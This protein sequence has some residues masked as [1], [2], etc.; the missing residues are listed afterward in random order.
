MNA[1]A[2]RP[3]P[4]APDAADFLIASRQCELAHLQHFLEL[5]RLIQT[6]GDLVHGLQQ[7]RGASNVYLGSAGGRFATERQGLLRETDGYRQAFDGALLEA[8]PSLI[9]HPVSSPLLNHVAC[10]LHGLSGLP[11]LRSRVAACEI[12]AP[13]ATDAYARL[14]HNLIA[15]VFEAADMAVDPSIAGLLVAMVHL[16]NGKELCGQER[17]AG[18]AGFSSGRFSD[19]LSERMVHLAEAQERCFEVF[20]Q[21]ASDDAVALWRDLRGHEREAQIEHLRRLGCSVGPY[22]PLDQALAD[23]WFALMSERM[24]ALKSVEN[25]LEARFHARCAERYA[26]ARHALAHQET[27]VASLT[28]GGTPAPPRLA[29]CDPHAEP[30]QVDA[31]ASEELAGPF[32]RSLL[33]LVQDQARRLQQMTDE[34]RTAKDALDDR[35]TQEKAVLLLMKHRNLANDDAHRLLRKLAMDQGKKLPEVARAVLAMADVLG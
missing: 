25:A 31:W 24:D 16:M 2:K 35:K 8:R 23:R 17:A 1:R 11:R 12:T 9:R 4:P 26:E 29:L 32:G 5:G 20:E 18:S 19:A 3:A 27:L 15:V 30:G 34:L 6:I 21:F 7:E 10:A 14:I 28:E 22:K 33:D 13:E